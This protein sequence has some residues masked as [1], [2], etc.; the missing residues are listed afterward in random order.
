MKWLS[1]EYIKQHSRIDYDC[2]DGLLELYADSA[3][4]TI[5]ELTRRTYEELKEM[6]G[7]KIHAKLYHAGLML[8]DNSYQNRT[9]SSTQQLSTIP[10]GN[11]D[12]L[13]KN[14]MKLAD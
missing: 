13:I 1:I 12:F 2:E 11:F 3:E 6:G 7:G 4:E 9:P 5:M 10:Y 14:Y 8:V